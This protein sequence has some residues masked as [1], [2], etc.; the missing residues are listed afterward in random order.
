MEIP[1][2]WG[3]GKPDW[4]IMLGI[5]HMYFVENCKT[6]SYVLSNSTL[7]EPTET[8]G[9]QFSI[10]PK[11]AKIPRDQHT[12]AAHKGGMLRIHGGSSRGQG[13]FAPL[14]ADKQY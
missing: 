9:D 14:K 5:K 4:S 11:E 1:C 2:C 10:S 12:S 13:I 8:T 6:S 3:R 7:R